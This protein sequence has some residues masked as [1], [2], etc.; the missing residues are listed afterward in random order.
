M[1]MYRVDVR[2]AEVYQL[3]IEASNEAQATT[4]ALAQL[5]REISE[6]SRE[7]VGHATPQT[8]RIKAG[9][10]SAWLVET[11]IE[12]LLADVRYAL[13][14]LRDIELPAALNALKALKRVEGALGDVKTG[15][16]GR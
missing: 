8:R 12:A 16:D 9:D 1:S 4:A 13:R 10:K 14:A 15:R 2:I 6:G 3:Q 11:K 5:K 7:R